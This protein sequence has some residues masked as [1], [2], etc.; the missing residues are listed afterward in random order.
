MRAGVHAG[1]GPPRG[2]PPAPRGPPAQW[3]AS[4][5]V[6]AAGH[7]LGALLPTTRWAESATRCDAHWCG[8]APA[9]DAPRHAGRVPSGAGRRR[10]AAGTL[11]SWVAWCSSSCSWPSSSWGW[12]SSPTCCG[13]R[14]SCSSWPGWPVWPSAPDAAEANPAADSGSPLTLVGTQEARGAPAQA[15]R[16]VNT[17]RKVAVPRFAPPVSGPPDGPGGSEPEP[18]AHPASP[19]LP[20]RP[21]ERAEGT[22]FTRA[23]AGFRG[24]ERAAS[25]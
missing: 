1:C 11:T 24:R 8:G 10:V 19:G 25:P 5:A 23:P 2:N 20:A 3:S 4:P 13:S 6:F 12:A 14:P 9:A 21:A 7:R 18:R 15:P 17:R 16:P 22:G